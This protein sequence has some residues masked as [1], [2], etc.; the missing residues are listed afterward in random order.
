MSAYVLPERLGLWQRFLFAIP[1]LGRIL[2]EVAYGPEE[3]FIYAL[4]TLVCLW[5][6]AILLFGLPGLYIPALCF[7]PVMF[8][9]LI[10]IT[11]G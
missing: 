11:R 3:N 1:L 9:L 6:C 8:L 2:K 7:V 4:A 10:T 5:G